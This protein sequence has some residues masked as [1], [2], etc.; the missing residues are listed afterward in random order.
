MTRFAY[1]KPTSVDQAVGLLNEPGFISRPLA[2]GTDIMVYA[3]QGQLWFD[4]LVD[5]SDLPE[6]TNIGRKG[7]RIE[8]GSAATFSAA[9]QNR[10][11]WEVAPM[12]VQACESVGGPQIRNIG[13]IGGNIANAA[14]C[15]DTLPP[16][17]CLGAIAHVKGVGG[18]RSIPVTDFSSRPHKNALI[19]GE[20]LT[21]V[22][23]EAPPPGARSIFIKLGRRNAQSISRLSMAAIG[24]L[25]PDGYVDYVSVAPGAALPRTQRLFAV[26]AKL[27]GHRPTDDLLAV[28]AEQAAD[29]M[30]E[31]TGRRWSTDYKEI[32]IKALVERA[33]RAVL[34]P[35]GAQTAPASPISSKR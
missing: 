35:K 24:Q 25:D 3:R 33:L 14:A 27:L 22:S 31:I 8:I 10:L 12:L 34:T 2:G 4:R 9:A 6:L 15:A 1:V 30:I 16:L 5:I 13:T 29:S 21:H 17:V 23:F 32:A 11:L 7:T 28:A 19:G 18:E 20:L 26:E